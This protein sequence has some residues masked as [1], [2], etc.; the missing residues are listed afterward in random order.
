VARVVA[1]ALRAL[2]EHLID[3][4]GMFPPAGLA[5][6][7][8]VEKYRAY[9][10]S[11]QSWMLG[12]FVIAAEQLDRLAASDAISFSVLASGD[13][14][15]AAAIESK[16][17]T[18]TPKPTYCEVSIDRLPAVRAAGSFAKIRT[19]GVTP[20]AIPG[21]EYIAE[22]IRRCAKLRVPF[23]A[24]AGLH[25]PIRSIHPLTYEDGAPCATM[26]G[27]VNVFMAAA[28]AW[29]GRREIEPILSETDPTA[30]AFDDAAHWRD[31]RLSRDEIADARTH[32]AHSFGSCSFE[33]PVR[34][35]ELLGSL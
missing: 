15:R 26:H 27:F 17:V 28:C 7:N 21:V 23:K 3:Y 29:H 24:T 35:L 30:F 12:R 22:Y 33:E 13:H 1:P 8:A 9:S 20:D 19:G 31:V 18:S 5:L 10:E 11:D 14:S 25:H 34:D 32:F 6:A 2:L 4:A 16:I